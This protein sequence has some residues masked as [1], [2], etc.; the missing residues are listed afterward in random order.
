V[1]YA[2]I[3][4]GDPAALAAAETACA[5][6]DPD[7]AYCAAMALYRQ[8]EQSWRAADN[9]AARLTL[10][11]AEAILEQCALAA[12]IGLIS[13]AR[14]TIQQALKNS[15]RGRA[16]TWPEWPLQDFEDRLNIRILFEMKRGLDE[17]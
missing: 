7:L 12:P 16:R 13:E 15:G 14:S 1:L 2:A 6:G 11:K 9:Q 10:Q 8:A 17:R 5:G 4:A 3:R